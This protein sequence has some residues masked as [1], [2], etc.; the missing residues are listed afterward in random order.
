[1]RRYVDTGASQLNVDE[2]GPFGPALALIW[3]TIHS[4]PP[5]TRIPFVL[6]HIIAFIYT[7][8]FFST[9]V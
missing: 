2:R 5:A 4:I 8:T 3:T 1:M 9:F 6:T 7:T